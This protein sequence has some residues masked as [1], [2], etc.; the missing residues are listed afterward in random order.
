MSSEGNP[1]LMQLLL[2]AHMQQHVLQSGMAN[3]QAAEDALLG[4][5]GATDDED[6]PSRKKQRVEVG[7]STSINVVKSSNPTYRS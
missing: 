7:H 3:A 2:Q 5:P 1:E 6:N 4:A